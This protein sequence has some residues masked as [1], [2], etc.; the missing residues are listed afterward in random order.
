MWVGWPFPPLYP[1]GHKRLRARGNHDTRSVRRSPSKTLSGSRGPRT[2]RANLHTKDSS[3][4][5]HPF[6]PLSTQTERVHSRDSCPPLRPEPAT[7]QVRSVPAVPPGSDGFLRIR[8]RGFVAP[9]S[10]PWGLPSFQGTRTRRDPLPLRH[11]ALRSFPLTGRQ[12]GH[13]VPSRRPETCRHASSASGIYSTIESV[14]PHE[15]APV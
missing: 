2:R 11:K 5:I 7:A 10:R 14:A 1:A 4:E 13:A 8:P 3:L 15:V 6:S 9:R 12:R